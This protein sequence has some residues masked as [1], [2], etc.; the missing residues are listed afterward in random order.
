MEENVIK[1]KEL[2]SFSALRIEGHDALIALERHEV[3]NYVT[4]GSMGNPK[5]T[6]KILVSEEKIEHY[7]NFK[8]VSKEELLKI[9][10]N[11]YSAIPKQ[12]GFILKENGVFYY[13]PIPSRL[14][15]SEDFCK[16]RI[17][18]CCDC[19]R[20]HALPFDKGGCNKALDRK[21]RIDKYSFISDGYEIFGT[22]N[23]AMPVFKCQYFQKEEPRKNTK[24]S[25]DSL[26]RLAKFYNENS[27]PFKK[28]KKNFDSFF[29]DD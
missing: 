21:L 27:I 7:L 25:N 16:G 17:H 15:F 5:L 20:M 22:T 28:G 8:E 19:A 1:R 13:T 10:T 26:N 6:E 4:R 29:D 23:N 14:H 18:L 11:S 12:P 3:W 9:R 2:K 24:L